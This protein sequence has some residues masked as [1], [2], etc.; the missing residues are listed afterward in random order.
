MSIL[1]LSGILIFLL[2]RLNQQFL[3]C[4]TKNNTI[5]TKKICWKCKL[6][7]TSPD[8]LNQRLWR[9]S[10]KICIISS[11]SDSEASQVWDA[12]VLSYA[13]LFCIADSV[14]VSWLL[15]VGLLNQRIKML[16]ETKEK[17]HYSQVLKGIHT[18]FPLVFGFMFYIYYIFHSFGLYPGVLCEKS[19]FIFLAIQLL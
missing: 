6:L 2:Q 15:E 7:D 17:L 13:M 9:W 14:S 5:T 8:L 11:P 3:R 16:P 10:S 4:I 19:T 12:L 1:V 18:C